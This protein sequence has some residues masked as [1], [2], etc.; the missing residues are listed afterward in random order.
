M[1][2]KITYTLETRESNHLQMSKQIK[3]SILVNYLKTLVVGPAE[4]FFDPATSRTG[5]A[6]YSPMRANRSAVS[7]INCYTGIAFLEK[8]PYSGQFTRKQDSSP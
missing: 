1:P 3:G 6:Q 5:P 7:L 8:V 4:A 2:Y